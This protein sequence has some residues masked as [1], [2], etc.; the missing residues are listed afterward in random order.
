MQEQRNA[1]GLTLFKT[2]NIHVSL[3]NAQLCCPST[4]YHVILTRN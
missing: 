2:T 4:E 3:H 1:L